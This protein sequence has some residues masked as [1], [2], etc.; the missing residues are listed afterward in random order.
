[1][2]DATEKLLRRHWKEVTALAEDLLV[3]NTLNGKEVVAVIEANQSADSLNEDDIIPKTLAA[4]RAQALAE[5]RSG[6]SGDYANPTPC[7]MGDGRF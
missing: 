6:K 2:E 3:N 5:I 1:M 4:I 7:Q